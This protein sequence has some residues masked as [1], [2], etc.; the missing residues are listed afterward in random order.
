MV[1]LG[2]LD[3][4]E[5]KLV[6]KVNSRV[7]YAPPGYLLYMREGMLLAHP[8]DAKT[9]SL[10]GE[11]TPIAEHL[12]NFSP[13]G[14]AAF[15][16][17]E[18]GVLAY[19]SGTVVSRLRFFNRAGKEIGSVGGAS[20]FVAPRFS[21]DGQKVAVSI[22][23]PRTGTNDIWIYDLTRGAAM[24]FTSEAGT[25]NLPVWSPDGRALAFT[26][27]QKGQPPYIHLKDLNDAGTG[28]SLV[29]PSWVQAVCDWSKD[30]NI[31]YEE[32]AP[33]TGADLFLLP[34]TGER[35]K[36]VSFLRTRFNESD[37]RFSPDGKWI[38]YSSNES[39][40]IEIYVRSRATPGEK[41]QVSNAGGVNIIWNSNGKEL[42]YISGDSQLM[43]VPVTT[44]NTFE[45]GTPVSL[46]RI[47]THQQ[48]YDVAPYDVAPDGQRFI[49]NSLTGTPALPINVVINWTSELK[50]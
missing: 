23:N 14:A 30:G 5:T 29:E 42:F 35:E 39:G 25:E 19:Q 18:N 11:P 9:L 26:A 43:A 1:M 50:H 20:D 6:M 46:F 13:T 41:W 4:D 8:F 47:T 2:S 17:S 15:S 34:M 21:P 3:V 36:P 24:R 12:K 49:V 10:T 28:A 32:W 40:K 45:A 16:V 27:D 37:A 33:E 48:E 38:A 22:V 44:G 7:L 31:L